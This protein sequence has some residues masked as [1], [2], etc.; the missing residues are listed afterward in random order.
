MIKQTIVDEVCDTLQESPYWET[1]LAIA[2]K[3]DKGQPLLV[4]GK[5][6]RTIIEVMYGYPAR[7]ECVDFDWLLIDPRDKK[8]HLSLPKGWH[9][10]YAFTPYGA[11]DAGV[12]GSR[13]IKNRNGLSIDLIST[14]GIE[15]IKN[16]R[17]PQGIVGYLMSV[18]LDIQ[19]IALDIEDRRLYGEAGANAIVNRQV[20]INNYESY[21]RYLLD[22]KKK[23]EPT[24]YIKDKAVSIKFGISRDFGFDG[25]L[26]FEIRKQRFLMWKQCGFDKKQISLIPDGAKPVKKP[27]GLYSNKMIKVGLERFVWD[28]QTKEWS[29]IKNKKKT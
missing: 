9:H 4:G 28:K 27:S 29:L 26:N 20:G 10:E 14:D 24:R 8:A 11:K 25:A 2:K 17:L 12:N 23:E 16:G 21:V 18:P 15:Q 5:L 7:A 3:H 1:V 6:Y 22:K 19:A 13:R